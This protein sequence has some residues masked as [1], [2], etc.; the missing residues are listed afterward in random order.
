MIVPMQEYGFLIYH[1][2]HKSFFEKLYSLGVVHIKKSD[3]SIPAEIQETASELEKVSHVLEKLSFYSSFQNYSLKGEAESEPHSLLLHTS[4][5]LA[6][7]AHYNV[8]LDNLQN[9]YAYAARWGPYDTSLIKSLSENGVSIRFYSAHERDFDERWGES[10]RLNILNFDP[11]F[12]HFI[13]FFYKDEKDD[14]PINASPMPE[15]SISE[16]EQEIIQVKEKITAL[17]NTLATINCTGRS[18]LEKYRFDLEKSLRILESLGQS[19]EKLDGKVMLARGFVPEHAK[20]T[21]EQVCDENKILYFN[22]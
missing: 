3:K 15:R 7:E 5:I 18:T 1:K 8:S 19:Q 12:I 22:M 20:K 14:L 9:E 11:P 21:V 2:D 10:Y 6:A 16:V 17:K 4:E 13:V